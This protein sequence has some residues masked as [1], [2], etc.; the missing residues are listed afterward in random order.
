[1]PRPI[2]RGPKLGQQAFCDRQPVQ[3]NHDYN[4]QH[5]Q[6]DALEREWLLGEG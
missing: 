5:P 3:S 2:E 4:L 1:M 6:D